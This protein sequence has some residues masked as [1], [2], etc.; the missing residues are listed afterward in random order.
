MTIPS[1]INDLPVTR[2][3]TNAFNGRSN[4]TSVTIPDSAS[5]IEYQAFAVCSTLTNVTMPESVTNLGMYAFC[6]CTSLTDMRIPGGVNSINCGAFYY[7]TGLSSV[8]IPE[9]FGSIGSYAFEGCSSLTNVA[10]PASVTNIGSYAFYCS[11]NLAGVYF[12]GN[13]PGAGASV[14]YEDTQ[15]TVYYLSGSIGWGPTFAGRPTALWGPQIQ[16]ASLRT[17]QFG[18]NI[19]GLATGK[20]W[21]KP[22]RTW[23]IPSGLRWAPTPSPTA[24]SISATPRGRII[25]HVSIA[26]ALLEAWCPSSGDL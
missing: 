22:A 10:I 3:G 17:D 8:T 7:C 18:F 6:W 2:I 26:S 14:F 15:A 1:A 5:S 21:W 13:A 24:P 23:R 4:L 20:L 19:G 11:T 16:A 12:Q 9:S 25:P